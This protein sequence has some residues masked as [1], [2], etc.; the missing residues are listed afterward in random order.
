MKKRKY[1]CNNRVINLFVIL[2]TIT[3]IKND[4]VVNSIDNSIAEVSSVSNPQIEVE[5]LGATPTNPMINITPYDQNQANLLSIDFKFVPQQAL[6]GDKVEALVTVTPPKNHPNYSNIKFSIANSWNLPNVFEFIGGNLANSE[7]YFQV[8]NESQVERYEILIKDTYEIYGNDFKNYSLQGQYSYN[9]DRDPYYISETSPDTSI[10]IKR[11][12]VKVSIVDQNGTD[13]TEYVSVQ[14]RLANDGEN[15]NFDIIEGDKI[16]DNYLLFDEVP[17]GDYFLEITELPNGCYV[18]EGQEEV[19][20]TVDYENNIINHTFHVQGSMSE[21]IRILEIEPADSFKL[22]NRSSKVQTGIET[23]IVDVDGSNY[24]AEIHHMTM[25]EFIAKTIQ[26]NG[27]YDVIVIG[28]WVDNSISA[29]NQF[30][31]NQ[32]VNLENDITIRKSEEIREFI[33]SGQL[34]YIDSSIKSLNGTKLA[35]NFNAGGLWDVTKDNLVSTKS[36]NS[37]STLSLESIIRNYLARGNDFKRPSITAT[38]SEGD[39][40]EDDLGNR[41][42]RKMTFNVMTDFER[43]EDVNFAL[44]LDINGDGL[45]KSDEEVGID[46]VNFVVENGKIK[47]ILEYDLY[48]D[49]PNFIGLLDWKVE[50]QKNIQSGYSKPILGY[51]TGNILFRRLGEKRVINVLQ[52][53]QYPIDQ[54]KDQNNGN[55]NLSEN[56]QFQNLLLEKE[57]QDYKIN[58]DV[59]S[60]KQFYGEEASIFTDGVDLKD[61]KYDMVI[62]GFRDNWKENIF[63]SISNGQPTDNMEA[64]NQLKEFIES[65]QSVM[66]T[67]DT[68][69]TDNIDPSNKNNLTDKWKTFALTRHFR[70]IIGQSRYWDPNNPSE[71]NLDGKTPIVHD[72]EGPKTNGDFYLGLTNWRRFTDRS[73]SET[74]F[75][76]RI[77]QS[78]ITSYPFQLDETLSVRTTHGQYF[79]LNLEDEDVVPWFTIANNTNKNKINQYDAMNSY[80]TYSKGNITFS[81]TGHNL[82]NESYPLSEMQLFVNTIVKAERSANHAP[83]IDSSLLENEQNFIYKNSEKFDFTI[84]LRDIDEDKMKVYVNLFTEDPRQNSE[85]ESIELLKKEDV[86]SGQSFNISSENKKHTMYVQVQAI[87]EHGASTT[88]VYTIIPSENVIPFTVSGNKGLVQEEL[89]LKIQFANNNVMFKLDSE[90]TLGLHFIDS[91]YDQI[92]EVNSSNSTI[93]Y[94]VQGTRE[95]DGYVSGTIIYMDGSTQ[96]VKIPISIVNPKIIVNVEFSDNVELNDIEVTLLKNDTLIDTKLITQQVVFTDGLSRGN[97]YNVQLTGLPDGLQ[98]ISTEITDIKAAQTVSEINLCY[99]SPTY[100]YVI[101]VGTEEEGAT[102]LVEHGLFLGLG[103]SPVIESDENLTDE[104]LKLFS[105]DSVISFG[106]TIQAAEEDMLVRFTKDVY[107]SVIGAPTIVKFI[108]GTTVIDESKGVNCLIGDDSNFTCQLSE[109]GSYLLLYSYKAVISDEE[110]NEYYIFRNNISLEGTDQTKDARIKVSKEK[111]LPNLF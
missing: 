71:L 24:L 107:G 100:Q 10:K 44:Y 48:K 86:S 1:C 7:L 98:I 73:S 31:Y 97:G 33:D 103:N 105:K 88:K 42:K 59:I 108:E 55:L 11:G 36:L 64:I 82:E 74:K 85:A 45:F 49:Y 54:L 4:L 51:S 52:I 20:I 77:N 41:D 15:E 46:S 6:I 57:V 34:V 16:E 81:G 5:Y 87:D 80:Y 29:D 111:D 102:S 94:N 21:P 70:D 84:T 37:Y 53:A 110:F 32:Y 96:K 93:T 67:H 35:G 106:A 65:G 22:T 18:A 8:S 26:L 89:E 58:I 79:Q 9:L 3:L 38:V 23:T 68:M 43:I 76:H 39:T 13:I 61:S 69:Y 56:E 90:N 40:F 47:Y 83:V 28:N 62:I 78:L 66:F 17:S 104:Q 101:K 50:V 19:S 72:F 91:D 63:F 2:L 99:D 27:Y 109:Q 75:V 14:L 12:Q 95:V 30:L 60:H 25:S 92:K